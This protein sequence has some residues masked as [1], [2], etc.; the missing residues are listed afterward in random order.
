MADYKDYI[1]RYDI[2]ANVINAAKG[3]EELER[4]ATKLEGP[5]DTLTRSITQISQSMYQLK[6]N[7]QFSFAPKIDTGTFNKQ[8]RTMVIQ[9]RNA[10]AEMHAAIY[11]A[12]SGNSAGTKALQKGGSKFGARSAADIS[13][14]IEETQN[15]LKTAIGAEKKAWQA[16]L[17][18]QKQELATAQKAES[19]ILAQ[20]TKADKSTKAS[21]KKTPAQ[22]AKLTNVTP[23]V[24]R[25]WK[26]AFG[27]KT[28]KNL[29]VNIR[30]NASGTNGALTVITKI[31]EALAGLQ[32]RGNFI[33]RPALDQAA[34][35]SAKA[36]LE[37]LAALS[38]TITAPFMVRQEK[39][40]GKKA[41]LITPLTKD[42]KTKLTEARQQVKNWNQKIAS[43]QSRLAANK[44]K[45]E[46]TPAPG[47]KGQIT[48]DTNA[49]ANYQAAKAEQEKI[50]KTLQ[51]KAPQTIKSSAKGI[52][53]LAIDI[54]GNITKI[55][56]SCP[57]PEIPAI[58]KITKI[59]NKL[60]K[61]VIIPA[62]IKINA[63]QIN[64]SLKT[65]P[66]PVLN[67]K[68]H[69]LTDGI[70]KQ[71]QSTSSQTKQVKTAVSKATPAAPTAITAQSTT[72]KSSK[73]G[74]AP[75]INLQ[76]NT[77]S[78]V[79][80]LEEFIALIR[81]NSPQTIALTASGTAPATKAMTSATPA[82][83]TATSV[84]AVTTATVAKSTS[85]SQTSAN[86]GT[87]TAIEKRQNTAAHLRRANQ[88]T[89][90]AQIAFAP[91]AQ[92]QKQ[93]DML[94]KYRKFF[95]GAVSTTGIAPYVGMEAPQMHRYLQGVANLMQQQ[96]VP[97]PFELKDKIRSLST[98]LPSNV[99]TAFAN[100]TP[101]ERYQTMRADAV[102]RVN[103]TSMNPKWRVQK[104]NDV[105]SQQQ[106]WRAQQQAMYDRLFKRN[107]PG[108]HRFDESWYHRA[109]MQRATE[110]RAMRNDA[111]AA[112]AKPTPF[113]KQE[114]ARTSSVQK[115]A[116]AF[117]TAQHMKRV[118]RL[119]AKAYNSMLPFATS[120]EQAKLLAAHRRYFRQATKTTG[121]T[122]T[123]NMPTSERLR[124][125][126]AVSKQMQTSNVA[127]PW[128][129]Q[130]H[131]NKLEEQSAPA[132]TQ[133]TSGVR[134]TMAVYG[135]NKPFFDRTR[136]WAYPFTGQTSF[137]ARTPMAVD[138]AKGMG[139]MF[140][141]GGAMSAIGNS[142]SQAMEYQ[143]TMRTTQAILQN[144]T[145][146]YTNSSF[147]NMES[148]V[149]DVG[150][151]TKFSAPEVAS[152]AKF[153]AMAGYDIDAINNSIR[154]I[155]DLALIGDLDLGET[156]DKMTNIMTTFQIAPEKMRQAANIMATTA[157]R[158]NTDLMM[159]AESAK[160]G[161]GVANMY[162]RNDPNLFGDTM[163]L[164]GVMGNA[165][166]QASSAGTALRMMYQNIF[167]PNKKQTATL[168]MMKE[169]Y[170]ITTRTKDGGYRAMSDILID[171]AQ[172]IPENKIADIVG[173]LFRITAQPGATATLLAAAGGDANKAN[174]IGAGIEA[175]SAKM[176]TKAGLSSL[177][178]LMLANR[179]SLNG[180]I[181]SSIA[182]E[183]Q[184]TISGLWA[185]VTST[186]TEG[187][188]QAFEKRQGGFESM[189]KS[190]RDYLAKPE[191]ISMMQNLI[192][193]IIEI[194]KVM[195]WF[196]K[197]WANLY[198][199]APGL[200]K[201]WITTQMF[202]TQLGT[203]ITP[204]ISLIAVF[205][206]LGGIM[207]KIA[208]LS[209]AGNGLFS[210]AS[211]GAAMSGAGRVVVAGGGAATS[212][213]MTAPFIVG[214]GSNG[215]PVKVS[216]N[217]AVRARNAVAA[218]KAIANQSVMRGAM[219]N[220]AMWA[221]MPNLHN[222]KITLDRKVLQQHSQRAQTITGIL[223]NNT[224][225]H[226]AEVK[227]RANRI[228]GLNRAGRAFKS[229]VMAVPTLASFTPMLSGLK[230]MFFSLFAGLAKAAGLLLNPITLA[231][232]AVIGLG[233]GI[234]KFAEHVKGASEGQILARK[235][236]NEAADTTYTELKQQGQWYN[237]MMSKGAQAPVYLGETQETNTATQY[238]AEQNARHRRYATVLYQMGSN[239]SEQ[240]NQDVV[241]K[242]NDVINSNPAYRL[243]LGDDYKA[244][245]DG[246]FG[247]YTG[248][249]D[250]KYNPYAGQANLGF[251]MANGWNH[252]QNSEK[253]LKQ[254]MVQES[255][256]LE[257][258]NDQRL[259]SWIKELNELWAN[260]KDKRQYRTLAQEKVKKY[261]GTFTT[262]LSAANMTPEQF[263]EV[264]NYS[265]YQP[266]QDAINNILNAT[267][268]GDFGTYIGKQ[269]AREQ[270]QSG[271][272]IEGTQQYYEAIAN[273]I[274][275]FKVWGSFVS[276]DGKRRAD[277]QLQLSALPDG[278]IDYSKII[279]DV[280]DKIGNFHLSLNQFS[281]MLAKVYQMMADAG[282]ISGDK[283]NLQNI[284]LR[285]MVSSH[286]AITRNDIIDY[287]QRNIK[288]NPNSEW[289]G[290]SA[291]QY[292][293]FVL[294]HKGN[295][296]KTA[297]RTAT[298]AEEKSYITRDIARRYVGTT[299]STASAP[300]VT[301]TSKPAAVSNQ[302]D[303]ASSYSPS[304]A[305]PTQ[306]NIN[307]NELAHFD[308]TSVA[309]SAEERDLMAAMESKISNAVYQIFATASNQ[310]QRLI[311]VT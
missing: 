130:S 90:T 302:K 242:W 8:L 240:A 80:K 220:A 83:P 34:F 255:L 148:T 86:K 272:L 262:H 106:A 142:F 85:A 180:D 135:G 9:T 77:T 266:Y 134:G 32:E 256:K 63:G 249:Y 38:R 52:K 311:D 165:G 82:A 215:K 289:A 210:S 297:K 294:G 225:A 222:S 172:R 167:K 163:A 156:A 29:T 6:Q 12:M 107:I 185:Q 226:Y 280:K 174:E 97:V 108:V 124:Y 3:L 203:L 160:Y 308:R 201:L 154:P 290:V 202:F 176:N 171:M 271:K 31:Q 120:K 257:S 206:R 40:A 291:Q 11:E 191:T 162:G 137:G 54:I 89:R 48:K 19:A 144:G 44:A 112:F 127:V 149:R 41:G 214:S 166:V 274:G 101:Y 17:R 117:N 259:Q 261:M 300:S 283:K 59:A 74:K 13:K 197:I 50:I 147:R 39:A 139:V 122:P 53:P 14:S 132:A 239:A 27:D 157:T 205:N 246:T 306:I 88:Y 37:E 301:K 152:A 70:T 270:L 61:E 258:V 150:I 128:Q 233:Y 57:S 24:I 15:K 93:A 213:A 164:F 267:I 190:L 173:N 146:S 95:Q 245:I 183:K 248:K 51:S 288:S 110:L 235:K 168:N 237:D 138:M 46:Q 33:I 161:G 20:Q 116:A 253:E 260:T 4:L 66:T 87:T 188:V 198:N 303:Y 21:V 200:I 243:A 67:V 18:Q 114:Q 182:L 196:I 22:P 94:V 184:N 28:L 169:Q 282:L 79:A 247:K 91:F 125:L 238:A 143:N 140:A 78:A 7:S 263:K 284:V 298:R 227:A 43:V 234:Y 273:I 223:N 209:F 45:Y 286:A 119:Q 207:G 1:V 241:R 115:S 218:N 153:L 10:A 231:T 68:A 305:R 72:I 25:E 187:I 136:R 92:T 216:G 65:I 151:K 30:G 208:G 254:A 133:R 181:A 309:S 47:L 232:G 307:I 113:E 64:T 131:I 299:S 287:Y 186:F 178:S 228:Y 310:A 84:T 285:Q 155:T 35:V 293:D 36:Q 277:L 55:T 69:L 229:A 2:Q 170:G 296:I 269:K 192:D 98:A 121:I 204:V 96:R 159:L 304:A 49:L 244:H 177:V 292:A 118:E 279:K 276:A 102:K 158:S 103:S 16:I 194:G 251:M 179:A 193:M 105:I 81:S 60:T 268:N 141:I 123:V 224:A 219:L 129:L 212:A 278:R 109:E 217:M 5:I 250:L 99:A 111:I 58:A 104:Q 76:L 221:P 42:E 264:D 126:Q 236:A 100:P 252:S 275:D 62:N 189:L 145:D 75:A 175:M 71:V 195:A 56:I 281:N 265:L 26:K 73:T 199:T 230:S 23:A 295:T 211:R